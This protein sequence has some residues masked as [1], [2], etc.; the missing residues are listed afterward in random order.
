MKKLFAIMVIAVAIAACNNNSD[1]KADD[2]KDSAAKMMDTAAQK[3]D[4]AAAK[5]MDTTKTKM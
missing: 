1:K 2:A 3:M 5:M 4:T